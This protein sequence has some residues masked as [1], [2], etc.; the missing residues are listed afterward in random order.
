MRDH[1]IS[2][3]G[4]P[5]GF[6]S[7]IIFWSQHYLLRLSHKAP[8]YEWLIIGW[9]SSRVEIGVA[10]DNTPIA[11]INLVKSAGFYDG[12]AYGRIGSESRGNGQSGGTSSHDDI[13]ESRIGAW[14]TKGAPQDLTQS[15]VS[16]GEQI[17]LGSYENSIE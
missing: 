11:V 1:V 6:A 10:R 2:S 3:R 14:E 5:E 4:T 7:S 16:E 12:D 17:Q 15:S 8:I 9:I 13:V